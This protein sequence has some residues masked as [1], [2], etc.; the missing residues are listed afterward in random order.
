MVNDTSIMLRVVAEVTAT[1]FFVSVILLTGNPISIAIAL[2]ASIFLS[3]QYSGGHLNPAVSFAMWL[4]GDLSS[5]MMILYTLAQLIG[6]TLALI[7]F[8]VIP[9][10]PNK[11]D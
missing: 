10:N 2:A 3:N 4:K 11:R 9:I 6:A 1:F 7:Y 8:R 5:S